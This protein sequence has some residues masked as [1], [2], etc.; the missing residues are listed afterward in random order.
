MVIQTIYDE[1]S[2][3][4]ELFEYQ[5]LFVSAI[6]INICTFRYLTLKLEIVLIWL[7]RWINQVSALP[8]MILLPKATLRLVQFYKSSNVCSINT[9]IDKPLDHLS[10]FISIARIREAPASTQPIIAASPTA[11]QPNTAAVLPAST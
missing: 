7:G 11:P 10:G 3:V 5:T 1:Y 6:V 9:C 4:K 8:F 2:F